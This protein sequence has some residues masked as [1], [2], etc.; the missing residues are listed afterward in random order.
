MQAL[1]TSN[2]LWARVF[3]PVTHTQALQPIVIRQTSSKLQ[4]ITSNTM[5]ATSTEQHQQLPATYKRLVA[6]RTASCFSEVA[7]VEEVPVPSPGENE[8]SNNA[9]TVEL[10]P[11]KSA[12]LNLRIPSMHRAVACDA[13]VQHIYAAMAVNCDCLA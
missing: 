2:V 8:A 12:H 4:A 3:Q 11:L 7:E 9:Q 1:P 13:H 6:K 10:M 5:Q